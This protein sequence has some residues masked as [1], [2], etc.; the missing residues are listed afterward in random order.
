MSEISSSDSEWTFTPLETIRCVYIYIKCGLFLGL[1]VLVFFP[2]AF[3]F[4]K[5]A[6]NKWLSRSCRVFLRL[7]GI[8]VRSLRGIDQVPADEPFIVTSNH[9]NFLEPFIY[10]GYYPYLLRGLEKKENFKIPIWGRWMRAIGQIEVDRENTARAIESMKKV[11]QVLREEKTSVLVLPEGTRTPN[12]KLQPFKRGPFRTAADAHVRILPMVCK[13]LYAINRKGDWRIK[14][15]D[16]QIV[17]GEPLGPPGHD[18]QSQHELSARVRAWMLGE[19][20]QQ[21]A[22]PTSAK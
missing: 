22:Y 15:G 9:V 8:R 20:G 5:A 18:A 11:A 10:Q 2:A 14:P 6:F 13:G 4:E 19:L 7:A 21:E 1:V 16:V 3:I 12:G 17:F